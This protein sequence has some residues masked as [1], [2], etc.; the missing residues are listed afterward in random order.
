M[1]IAKVCRVAAGGAS[2]ESSRREDLGQVA[3]DDM[4][5]R[6]A[7]ALGQYHVFVLRDVAETSRRTVDIGP[8]AEVGA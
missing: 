3:G 7:A 1:L 4:R 2:N 5:S 6:R 8:H